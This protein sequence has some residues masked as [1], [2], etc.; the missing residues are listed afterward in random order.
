MGGGHNQQAQ[1]AGGWGY[2]VLSR[3]GQGHRQRRGV[4]PALQIYG[5]KGLVWFP[6]VVF[7]KQGIGR[8]HNGGRVLNGQIRRGGIFPSVHVDAGQLHPRGT[9]GPG[10]TGQHFGHPAKRSAFDVHPGGGVQIGGR[11]LAFQAFGQF[12]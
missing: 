7:G 4:F 11:L 3:A 8:R 12:F 2:G 5:Q 6:C 9:H 10:H 1:L